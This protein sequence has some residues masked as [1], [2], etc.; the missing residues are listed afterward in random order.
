MQFLVPLLIQLL[1]IL[2]CV[3]VSWQFL[4]EV[5]EFLRLIILSFR[6]SLG[7]RF[8]F[9]SNSVTVLKGFKTFEFN[10]LKPG[11]LIKKK[12]QFLLGKN[13]EFIHP[14]EQRKNKNIP[15]A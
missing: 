14:N 7:F 2:L 15:F 4:G 9:S 6:L 5:C 10:P 13:M 1:I 3:V 8:F 12:F 11:N